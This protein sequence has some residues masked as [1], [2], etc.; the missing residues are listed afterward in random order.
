MKT[1]F[2]ILITAGAWLASSSQSF[3][4]EPAAPATKETAKPTQAELEAKFKETLKQATFKGRWNAIENGALGP[5]KEDSYSISS[6]TKLSGES[7]IVSAKMQYGKKEL[8]L[9]IPVKV[10]WAGD[11]PIIVVE[12]LPI[13]GGGVYS[14]R[15]LVY[16][17]TY[18]GTWSG[19]DHAGLLSGIIVKTPAAPPK[20][21]E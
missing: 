15:V 6:A 1:S 10:R 2:L 4:Q 5:E 21:A 19:G 14:A 18:A 3:A 11:T 13:P 7:W 17:N 20:A 9:P 16:D 8:V 12:K